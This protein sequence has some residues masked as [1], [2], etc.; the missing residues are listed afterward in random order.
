MTSSITD[1]FSVGTGGKY[2]KFDT[3]GKTYSGKIMSISEPENQTD[4]DT[5]LPI[6]GKF[7]IRIVLATAERDADDQD[8]DGQRTV[9]V[10][11]GWMK[12][13]IAEACRTAGAKAPVIGGNLSV[14]YTGLVPNSR[15]KNYSATYVAGNPAE[16][17][18]ETATPAA[19]PAAAAA[20]ANDL[21]PAGIDAAAWASMPADAKAAVRASMGAAPF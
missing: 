2:A 3:V 11:S 9:Y 1:F 14:T 18:F 5:K 17:F 13:A 16:G 10:A 6:E 20:P 19:A 15:A 7:Q 4:F 12:G 8:D 21:P